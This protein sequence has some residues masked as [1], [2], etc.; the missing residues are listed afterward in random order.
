[1]NSF[2]ERTSRW[3]RS[4]V[5]SWRRVS[6]RTCQNAC[7]HL[8][9]DAG[10]R[11]PVVPFPLTSKVALHESRVLEPPSPVVW[12]SLIPTNRALQ[13][14]VFVLV[15]I[16]GVWSSL[17][18]WLCRQEL[19]WKVRVGTSTCCCPLWSLQMINCCSFE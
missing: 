6:S 14:K 1:M 9:S 18:F 2:Y 4:S 13:Y 19:H 8:S 16:Q 11:S 12:G 15:D 10:L 5:Q 7:R 17:S 3:C